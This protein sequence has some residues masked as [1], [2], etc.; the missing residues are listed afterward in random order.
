MGPQCFTQQCGPGL[1]GPHALKTRSDG[2]IHPVTQEEYKKGETVDVWCTEEE[3]CQACATDHR[4]GSAAAAA[5]KP[6]KIARRQPLHQPGSPSAATAPPASAHQ[7]APRRPPGTVTD[8]DLLEY[9]ASYDEHR[10]RL[11]ELQV[12]SRETVEMETQRL[13]SAASSGLLR[14]DAHVGGS[15]VQLSGHAQQERDNITEHARGER[16]A[17]RADV[18][19]AIHKEMENVYEHVYDQEKRVYCVEQDI[20]KTNVVVGELSGR[21]EAVEQQQQVQQ[22][23]QEHHTTAAAGAQATSTAGARQRATRG[24]WL[25]DRPVLG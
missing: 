9:A 8:A 25:D 13:K 12:R 1:R 19:G 18:F 20:K 16:G 24:V 22:Q 7:P 23:P 4:N 3:H 15:R 11:G 14:L 17:L 5:A 21:M 2:W 10:E 6:R